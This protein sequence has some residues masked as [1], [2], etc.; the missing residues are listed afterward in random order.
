MCCVAEHFAPLPLNFV[1][2][3]AAERLALI[4]QFARHSVVAMHA[5]VA[6]YSPAVG[7]AAEERRITFTQ[8][9][10]AS[11]CCRSLST[12]AVASSLLL[13]LLHL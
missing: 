4:A 8:Q 1:L 9:P 3:Q 5:I 10:A 7:L 2:Q 11:L 6:P 12:H 13:L